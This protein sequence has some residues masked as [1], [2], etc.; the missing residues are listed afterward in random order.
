MDNEGNKAQGEYTDFI[1]DNCVNKKVNTDYNSIRTG[2]L[3]MQAFAMIILM[4]CSLII[5]G[6]YKNKKVN[7]QIVS[8]N[9]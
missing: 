3:D 5:L 7:I 6:I 8:R 4:I 2:G 9:K 1:T